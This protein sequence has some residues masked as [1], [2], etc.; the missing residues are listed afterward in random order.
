MKLCFLSLVALVLSLGAPAQ[1]PSDSSSNTGVE[2]LLGVNTDKTKEKDGKYHAYFALIIRNKGGSDYYIPKRADQLW[3]LEVYRQDSPEGKLP[4]RWL[5]KGPQVFSLAPGE[6]SPVTAEWEAPATTENVTYIVVATFVP[7]GHTIK[8]QFVLPPRT[9]NILFTGEL[10]GYYR[11]P[12]RQSLE[13]RECEAKNP[14]PDASVFFSKFVHSLD[15]EVRLGMGDNFGPNYYSRAFDVSKETVHRDPAKYFYYW[16]TGAPGWEADPEKL[17]NPDDIQNGHGTIPTDNVACFFL[18]AHYDA[19]VPAMHDFYYGPERLRELARLL[20]T[21]TKKDLQPVQMLAANMVIKTTWAK[22]GHEAVPDSAKHLLPFVTKYTATTAS[23]FPGCSF[24]VTAPSDRGF[25][26]PWTQFVR[27]TAKGC[28]EQFKENGPP[29]FLC[30]AAGPDKRPGD[31]D[32]FMQG[33]GKDCKDEWRLHF[34]ADATDEAEPKKDSGPQE[35]RYSLVPGKADPPQEKPLLIPGHNYAVCIPGA[36]DSS[37][38]RPYCVRFSVYT[39]FLQ[40]PDWPEEGWLKGGSDQE[41]VVHYQNPKLYVVKN[42]KDEDIKSGRTPVVIFGV[43]D[44]QL[45]ED[46]GADNFS[47]QTVK[48]DSKS[49]HWEKD[50]DT[51]VAIVDP[52]ETLTQLQGYF[53]KDYRD[54][55][56]G[57]A[58]QGLRVLLAQMSPGRAKQ[59]AAHMP[60][61]MRFD[62]I[63][64]AADDGLATPNQELHIQ[65]ALAPEQDDVACAPD[66]GDHG[67]K[68]GEAVNGA[69]ATPATFLAVPPSHGQAEDRHLQARRLGITTDGQS[70]WNYALSGNPIPVHVPYAK[71][72]DD[73]KADFWKIICR[74]LPAAVKDKKTKDEEDEC[75]KDE[76][77]R[78]TAIQHLALWSMRKKYRADIALLQE[79]DFYIHGVEDYLSEHCKSSADDAVQCD[80]PRN[81]QEMLDRVIWKG[82]LIKTRLIK[83]SVLK[84][85]LKESEQFADRE[86]KIYLHV[87]DAGRALVKLGIRKDP[88]DSDNFLVNSRPL[89][90]N[91]IYAVAT[92]DYIA[93]GDTGYPE[94]AKPP[95]GD[96]D[97]PALP[98]GKIDRIA[99]VACEEVQW[100]PKNCQER[101]QAKDYFDRAANR[102]PDDPGAGNTNLH[103]FYAWTFLRSHLGQQVKKEPDATVLLEKRVN[104]EWS[105]EQ[106]SIG[107]S[108]LSH[109]DSTQTLSQKFGGVLNS[110][111]NANR[112]HSWDWDANSKLTFYHPKTDWFLEER[113]QYSSNFIAQAGAPR[114]ETQSNN[115]VAFDGGAYFHLYPWRGKELPQLSLVLSGHF[116]TQVGDPI[117]VLTLN[118]I[119]PSASSTILT[120]GQGRTV[121]LLGRS[122]L[123]W[124]NR[125]SYIEAGLEGGSTLNAIKQFDI[126]VAPGGASVPCALEASVSL[127]NCLNGFN[128]NNP[129]TPVTGSSRVTLQRSPQD[130][131]GAYWRIGMTVPINPVISYNFQDTSEYFF[132][133]SGDNSADTRFR[134]ELVSSVRFMVLPNL[135]FEPTYTIF[136]YENKL[137][138]NFL[139]QQRYSVKINYSFNISNLHESKRQFR[140]AKESSE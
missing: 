39:P 19:I 53:E 22:K 47:W 52:V 71:P 103:K 3:K 29:V 8:K 42:D 5:D 41:P 118:A 68:N 136:L 76:M 32:S 58:F 46:I 100:D 48:G 75:Y 26:F 132:L 15:G 119:S 115:L 111:A 17:K 125:K 72:L 45:L 12:N 13:D 94:L 21:P 137:D 33:S 80:E 1:T 6:E 61:C 127:T 116:E 65:P 63:L 37:R 85:I 77:K 23:A 110:Q 117:T 133:S 18:Q 49:G 107:F 91:A 50:Y 95:A 113:L 93:L 89:D 121:G 2:T 56:E 104:W 140:Y 102:E 7:T 57:K 109:N 11:V 62:V 34:D 139:L 131:Y 74:S 123:S 129:T 96:L 27:I 106:L 35:L 130:R 69:L 30:R 81:I 31:P 64:S 114:S 138:Y 98:L 44:P 54:H 122:G 128:Q 66:A 90:P 9:A 120:F 16:D 51:Q 73:V 134:H 79:R 10:M 24:E 99:G 43:V 87:S 40:Y 126:L 60:R 135:S 36:E 112:A 78:T 83:G 14:S 97:Q 86:K 67:G 4:W 59:L 38:A 20:A 28:T 82:D 101:I 84:S 124:E 55:H 108:G 105:I 92:S 25:V 88:N 70:Y